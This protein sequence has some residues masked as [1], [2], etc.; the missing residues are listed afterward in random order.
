MIIFRI[1]PW[2]LGVCLLA[3]LAMPYAVQAADILK[4]K[5][6][7]SY[8]LA[9]FVTWPKQAQA[10]EFWRLCYFSEEYDLVFGRLADKKLHGKVLRT[11]RLRDVSGALA[12]HIIYIDVKKRKLL[13]R[14]FMATKNKP[15]LTLSDSTGFVEQGGMVEIV[16]TGTNIRF[17][18]NRSE[19]EKSGLMMSSRALK[20]A[21]D[22]K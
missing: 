11:K 4:L 19:M 2:Y 16:S 17:K 18:V 3:T 8:N 12:C 21:I 10:E 5:A 15:I 9:K 6:S 20:L 22:V 7:L 1:K 14:L 13:P